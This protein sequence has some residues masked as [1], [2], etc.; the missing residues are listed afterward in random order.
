[1]EQAVIDVSASGSISARPGLQQEAGIL[2]F[3]RRM[4][5]CWPRVRRQIATPLHRVLQAR[6]PHWMQEIHSVATQ[7]GSGRNPGWK[8]SGSQNFYQC[9]GVEGMEIAEAA[10]EK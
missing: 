8:R 6:K 4:A 3:S 10:W 9:T 1:M 7:A 2:A 5:A